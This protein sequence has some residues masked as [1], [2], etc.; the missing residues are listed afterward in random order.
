MIRDSGILAYAVGLV[1]TAGLWLVAEC[2]PLLQPFGVVFALACM[3]RWCV[4]RARGIAHAIRAIVALVVAW[5]RQMFLD[6][7][8]WIPGKFG[9]R[10]PRVIA[11]KALRMLRLGRNQRKG[12]VALDSGTRIAFRP[13]VAFEDRCAR[14]LD[15]CGDGEPVADLACGHLVHA[16][17]AFVCFDAFPRCPHCGTWL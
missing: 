1:A 16:E 9:P 8:G 6:A 17:C 10:W 14:C 13:A 4:A 3:V 12:E 15:D 2:T 5:F 11:T 7:R